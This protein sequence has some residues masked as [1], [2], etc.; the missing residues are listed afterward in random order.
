MAGQRWR[1]FHF[2]SPLDKGE[3]V[4]VALCARSF[5]IWITSRKT[6][7]GGAQSGAAPLVDPDDVS[8]R[9]ADIDDMIDAQD[10]AEDA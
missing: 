7:D 8:I 10:Q 1:F 4:Q 5:A 3:T 2:G 6:V 9:T